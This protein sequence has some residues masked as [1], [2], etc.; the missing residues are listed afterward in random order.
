MVRPRLDAVRRSRRARSRPPARSARTRGT[1][2]RRPRRRTCGSCGRRR[3]MLAVGAD[4]DRGVRDALVALAALG[5]RAGDEVDR[6]ARA[7]VSRAQRDRPAVEGLGAG[8]RSRL[9]RRGCRAARA[10]P[11]ARRRRRRR[12][13]RGAPPT[14][15]C[16]PRVVR[17]LQ[18]NGGGPHVTLLPERLTDQSIWSVLRAHARPPSARRRRARARSAAAAERA[19]R[20]CA[21][22]AAEALALR[23]RVPAGPDAV[24]GRRARGRRAAA[25]VGRRA[26]GRDAVRGQPRRRAERGA[27]A[28]A[29]CSTWSSTRPPAWRWSRRTAARTSG[30]ASRRP[31]RCAGT[32]RAAG[33]AWRARRRRRLRRRVGRLPRA[34][35]AP[36]AGRPASG[37]TEDG[38]AR[39]VEPGRRRARRAVGRASAPSG[40][41]AS[42]ARFRRR[43]SRR[44]SSRVGGLGFREWSA[45]ESR[46]EPAADAQQLPAAFRRVQRRAAGRFAPRRGLWGDG[47]A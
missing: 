32:V 4:V 19:C 47:G 20:R 26:A 5:D 31:C 46:T 40:S 6:R 23:G 1:P 27:C 42:R 36:G 39:G 43:S 21:R 22:P 10:A 12:R 9:T 16:D 38:R 30:R 14:R 15:G 18:L 45:R 2:R 7:R 33:R 29:A 13:A 37:A 8:E 17:R 44:T 3:W 25:L 11:P 28:C 41:T 24:R 35:H 34:A